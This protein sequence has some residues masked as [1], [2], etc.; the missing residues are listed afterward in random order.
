[1]TELELIVFDW[2]GTIMDSTAAISLSICAAAAD[3]G[4][5]VPSQREAADVIGLSM[6]DALARVVPDLTADKV[7]EFNDRYRVHYMAS[8][9]EL[10]PFNGI[11]ELLEELA[12]SP[13]MVAVA[14]GKSRGGLIRVLDALDWHRYFLST[15]CGDD[16]YPKPHPWMLEDL[17]AELGV[18][19]TGTVMV[20]DTTHDLGMARAAGV[21]AIGVTYGAQSRASLATEPHLTLVDDVAGLRASLQQLRS[22][23]AVG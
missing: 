14:T 5:R 18:A 2:D 9:P 21:S 22:G 8:D 3:L 6:R 12:A 1:M 7:A 11:P 15:R 13:V 23:D 20:G 16:R 10:L 19:H 4:L 17:I